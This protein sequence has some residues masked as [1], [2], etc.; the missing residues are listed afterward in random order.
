MTPP[1]PIARARLGSGLAVTAAV[2]GAAAWLWICWCLFPIRGWNDVRL[3][4]VFGLKLGLPL[5]AGVAGPVGTW[6]YGPLPVLLLWPATWA[7]DAG[8]ALLIA[9]GINLA[10]SLGAIGCVCALWP[11]RNAPP[12]GV[13]TRVIAAALTVALLP[14]STWQYLQADNTAVALGLLANLVLVLARSPSA[15][16]GAALL[17]MAG[18]L[19]KQTSIGVPVAQVIWL[20]LVE[21]RAAARDHALRLIACGAALGVLLFCGHDANATWFNLVVTPASLPWTNEPWGRLWDMAPYLAVFIGLP[22]L[23]RIWLRRENLDRD[24]ALP[25]L[26]WLCAWIPG[27]PALLKTGG[28]INNLHSFPLWLAPAMVIAVLATQRKL[29]A[30]K[31]LVVTA[32]IAAVICF[33][34]IASVPSPPWQ[35]NLQLYREAGELAKARPGQIWFPWHPLVTIFSENQ[36]YHVE[37][38]MYVR[39]LSGHPLT[40]TDAL[41]HLPPRMSA[42][43]LP[44]NATSWG[45]A[46]TLGPKDARRTDSGLWTIYSWPP[47][48][49]H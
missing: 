21:N 10:I 35:P 16:W 39:A 23:L 24:L 15:R 34:R 13:A 11:V 7:A 42:I 22:F 8:H 46:L 26:A 2:A 41:L 20:A 27:L 32:G 49:P 40:W 25:T 1:S 47:P 4:P 45:I 37:D 38:G 30:Q 43:A 18:M 6:M 3:A 19:C 14:R 17:A 36:L 5:Y 44:R 33:G 28:T 31:A 29:G 9:G 48:D 12:P